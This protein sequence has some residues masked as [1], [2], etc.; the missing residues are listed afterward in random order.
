L[1]ARDL[2][3][4]SCKSNRKFIPVIYKDSE[5]TEKVSLYFLKICPRKEAKGAK[6]E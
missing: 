3:K 5:T 1:F 4:K 2:T 6:K